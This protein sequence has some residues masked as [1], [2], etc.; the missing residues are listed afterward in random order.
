MTKKEVLLGL[1]IALVVAFLLSPFA[2]S[3]PDGLER[4]AQ[5]LGFLEKGEGPPV[6]ASPAPDYAFPGVANKTWAT[7]IAGVLG[8][9]AMFGIGYGVAS[10]IKRRKE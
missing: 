5:N 1:A 3:M 6:L 7:S 9:L 10:L 2:S 8:T 4:V